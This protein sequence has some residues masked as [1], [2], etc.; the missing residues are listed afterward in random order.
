MANRH[1]TL[2][3][4]FWSQAGKRGPDDCWLWTGACDT[5][6]YGR[7]GAGGRSRAAHRV[8]YELAAGIKIPDG[9]QACHSCDVRY[10][11]GDK[12]Y[13]RCVNSAHVWLGT[14]QENMDDLITKGRNAKGA[15]N[16]AR[17]HPGRMVKRNRDWMREHPESLSRGEAHSVVTRR[18]LTPDDVRA[19]RH[20]VG[21]GETTRTVGHRFGIAF[22]TVSVIALRKSWAWLD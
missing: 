7:I 22:Q 9:I 18:K 17:L 19:I 16:G 3:Q 8:A 20:A 13:K 14:N 5:N 4:R 10:A 2:V 11:I 1:L 21:S 15:R 6:G 12:T